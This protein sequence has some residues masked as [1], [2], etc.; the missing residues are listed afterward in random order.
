MFGVLGSFGPFRMQTMTIRHRL[1]ALVAVLTL[2]GCA[3]PTPEQQFLNDAYAALGGRSRIEAAR[4]LTIEA[5]GVNYNLGQ[6]LIPDAATQT[7]EIT[8][9]QRVIDI[10]NSRQRVEQVRTPKFASSRGRSRKNRSR[11]STARPPST[12]APP[13]PS[14]AWPAAR[15]PTA[16]PISTTIPSSCCARRSIPPRRSRMSARPAPFARPTLPSRVA[17][18]SRSRSTRPARHCRSRHAH[19]TPI[20]AT[21]S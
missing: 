19:T 18:C 10:A 8:D 5:T 12:S 2:A 14:P 13:G 3:P 11:V 7:F 16:A 9:Y 17:P 6:D 1:S 21:S 20:W 15:P 4:H